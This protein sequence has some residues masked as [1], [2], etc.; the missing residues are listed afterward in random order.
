MRYTAIVVVAAALVAGC[1]GARVH[2]HVREAQKRV[3]RLDGE[4]ATPPTLSRL[5]RYQMAARGTS[6]P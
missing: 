3:V 5:R 2:S 4:R 6:T 1:A